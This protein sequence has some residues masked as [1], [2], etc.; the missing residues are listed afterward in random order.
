MYRMVA[1]HDS[2]V[3]RFALTL[4]PSPPGEGLLRPV[5]LPLRPQGE[6]GRGDEGEQNHCPRFSVVLPEPLVRQEYHTKV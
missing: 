6:G 2:V 4:S 3:E 1:L 5:M